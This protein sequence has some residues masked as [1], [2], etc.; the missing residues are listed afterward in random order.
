MN[1][2]ISRLFEYV[3]SIPKSFYFCFRML[4]FRQALRLPVL[5]RYNTKLSSLKGHIK[6][7]SCRLGGG[8]IGF[9]NVGVFDKKYQR[10][11]LYLDGNIRVYGDFF[12]GYGSR[13]QVGKNG[14]LEFGKNFHITACSTILAFKKIKFGC[15][16]LISWDVLI[17]DTD[18]H[19]IYDRDTLKSYS[20]EKEIMIGNHVWIGCRSVLLKGCQISD[21]SIIA[22]NTVVTKSFEE[23]SV[24]IAGTPAN[25]MKRNV[26]WKE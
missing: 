20:C 25:I 17:M 15:D 14:Y 12:I 16:V 2:K 13:I 23:D 26:S 3:Y 4:P 19:N 6:L 9:G 21:D 11:V 8:R 5:V 7:D 10:T 22:A 1:N 24:I 18:F